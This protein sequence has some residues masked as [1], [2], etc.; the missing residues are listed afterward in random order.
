MRRYRSQLG[1]KRGL[2]C[3]S[4]EQMAAGL[5]IVTSMPEVRRREVAIWLQGPSPR[6]RLRHQLSSITICLCIY[7]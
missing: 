5:G 3:R 7:T 4:E 1:R 6:Q 2:E